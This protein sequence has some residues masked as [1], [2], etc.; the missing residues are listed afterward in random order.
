MNKTVRKQAVL[1]MEEMIRCINDEYIIERWL[2]AGVADGDIRKFDIDEVDEGYIEDKT[3]KSLLQ[4][5]LELMNIAKKD[6]GLY[7]DG[8]GTG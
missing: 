8:I 3:F 6:G 7:I 2:M 4:L 5:F 1:A